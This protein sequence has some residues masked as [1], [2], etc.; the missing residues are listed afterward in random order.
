LTEPRHARDTCAILRCSSQKDMGRAARPRQHMAVG[1]PEGIAGAGVS[2]YART[3]RSHRNGPMAFWVRG[4]PTESCNK[5]VMSCLEDASRTREEPRTPLRSGVDHPLPR[6][7][8]HSSVNTHSFCCIDGYCSSGCRRG[9]RPDPQK[10]N[11]NVDSSKNSA[12]G[13]D[14][15]I[16]HCRRDLC[17]R[18]TVTHEYARFRM[19]GSL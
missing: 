3:C 16:V 10:K 2:L 13:Y 6:G 18:N 5:G 8:A 11:F 1:A 7:H 15:G 4:M 17:S 12:L 19:Q 9:Q 14:T